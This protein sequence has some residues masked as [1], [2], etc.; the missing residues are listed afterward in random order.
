MGV[1]SMGARADL[2]AEH[3]AVSTAVGVP[4]PGPAAVRLASLIPALRVHSALDIGCDSGVLTEQLAKISDRVVATDVV[5]EALEAT[6]DCVPVADLRL[7][8]LYEPAGEERFDLIVCN[9]PFAV[10]PDA[11]AVDRRGDLDGHTFSRELVR[12]AWGHLTDG[13]FAY[14]AVSWLRPSGLYSWQMAAAASLGL[15][16]A[17]GA[18]VIRFETLDAQAYAE[19]WNAHLSTDLEVYAATVRRWRA[20]LDELRAE[21]F[22]W[23]VV[24]LHRTLA[25]SRAALAFEDRAPLAFGLE[26]PLSTRC[27]VCGRGGSDIRPPLAGHVLAHTRADIASYAGRMAL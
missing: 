6:R 8:S 20:H 16:E 22:E 10:T 2:R 14:L 4:P 23:G 18:T 1:A 5:P 15:Q 25:H 9:A 27:F 13:G 24:I 7:G 3:Y 17:D 11:S 21:R 12:G 26:T 19:T